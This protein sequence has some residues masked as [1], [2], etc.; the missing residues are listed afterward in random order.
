MRPGETTEPQHELAVIIL[1]F[2]NKQTE[3]ATSSTSTSQAQIDPK[4]GAMPVARQSTGA[5][6]RIRKELVDMGRDP[7]SSC[8]AGPIGED[9]VSLTSIIEVV[10]L[11]MST[12]FTWQATVM[13][14]VKH[15][16]E[17]KEIPVFQA[18]I[19]PPL[20]L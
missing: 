8:S 5:L 15:C 4:D 10:I 17:S 3:T 13:G 16:T 7:P 9:W 14:P 11:I 2:S 18:N 6:S 20:R 12:Q 19:Y 1:T